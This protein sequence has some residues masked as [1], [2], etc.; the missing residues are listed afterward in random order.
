MAAGFCSQP[1]EREISALDCGVGS[2]TESP[3]KK[4]ERARQAYKT[5][6]AGTSEVAIVAVC[7]DN[8]DSHVFVGLHWKVV[9]ACKRGA[10]W[11]HEGAELFNLSLSSVE[12]LLQYYCLAAA[13]ENWFDLSHRRK[14]GLLDFSSALSIKCKM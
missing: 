5:R 11:E 4:L 8:C 6:G 10:A 3:T 12:A 13:A 7:R 2:T 1:T 9:H 14:K